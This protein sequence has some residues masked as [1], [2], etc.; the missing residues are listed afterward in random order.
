MP[1]NGLD[2]YDGTEI[3]PL[4]LDDISQIEPLREGEVFQ[5]GFLVRVR[6]NLLTLHTNETKPDTKALL[7]LTMWQTVTDQVQRESKV[8]IEVIEQFLSELSSMSTK[9]VKQGENL[10]HDFE[11]ICDNPLYAPIVQAVVDL[12]YESRQRLIES[13]TRLVVSIAHKLVKKGI[14]RPLLDMVNDGNMGLIKAAEMYDYRKGFKFSTYATYWIRQSIQRGLTSQMRLIRLPVHQEEI[15]S[16]VFKIRSQLQQTLG[17]EP[18]TDELASAYLDK[19]PPKK[20]DLSDSRIMRRELRKTELLI[21]SLISLL[22][23]SSLETP[24]LD[25]DVEMGSRIKD[26]SVNVE[27]SFELRELKEQIKKSLA[28]L[29]DRERQILSLRYG[30][31][32]EERMSL[33]QIAKKLGLS[34][35]RIR[36]IESKAFETIRSDPEAMSYII[37]YMTR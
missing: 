7:D 27:L 11:A 9:S 14:K 21:L 19:Y 35:E 33:V 15:L 12:G 26:P 29:S 32:T 34:R 1:N 2:R 8:E 18:H 5:L 22:E 20:A 30:L 37:D 25:G 28:N 10:T 23:V 36:Q 24:I 4:Y 16:R 31:E 6:K 17:R 3:V 13:H